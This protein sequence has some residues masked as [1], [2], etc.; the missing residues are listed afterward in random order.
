MTVIVKPRLPETSDELISDY[1][2]D[3]LGTLSFPSF[4]A[5]ENGEIILLGTRFYMRIGKFLGQPS[6]A[7]IAKQQFVKMQHVTGYDKKLLK[8]I[9]PKCPDESLYEIGLGPTARR[10]WRP[11]TQAADDAALLS[12]RAQMIQQA[13]LAQTHRQY[14]Q[15]ILSG[16]GISQQLNPQ[17][18]GNYGPASRPAL[19]QSIFDE[20]QNQGFW[21]KIFGG[22]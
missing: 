15:G 10:T 2:T 22:L 4:E 14:E 20:P 8:V 3:L 6:Q 19:P 18:F 11:P 5:T 1:L 9:D 17:P 16:Q 13:V 21:Q 12:A 7:I